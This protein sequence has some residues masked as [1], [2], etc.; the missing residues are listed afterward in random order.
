MGKKI[1]EEPI[2]I[3]LDGTKY[4]GK[5][6]VVGTRVKYQTIHYKDLKKHDSLKITKD[7]EG[8]ARGKA[9]LILSEL[10]KEF[11]DFPRFSK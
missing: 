7:R 9:I 8:I 1:V 4:F 3:E 6:V 10:V 2:E 11:H 5:R